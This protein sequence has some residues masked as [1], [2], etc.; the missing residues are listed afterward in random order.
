MIV[1]IE[2]ASRVSQ[3]F[4][5]PQPTWE[6]IS[7]TFRSL[8]NASAPGQKYQVIVMWSLSVALGLG[9]VYFRKKLSIFLFLAALVAVPFLGELI[10]SI[11]RPIFLIEFDLDH[12]PNV[13]AAGSRDCCN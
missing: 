13:P 1:F 10:V 2:Q 7:Q 11:R 6:I 8:I 5:I 9:L 4:W 12:D 3:E